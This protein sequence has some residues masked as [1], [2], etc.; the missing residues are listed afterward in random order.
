MNMICVDSELVYGDL[1]AECC[2]GE[3]RVGRVENNLIGEKYGLHA[4]DI[5]Y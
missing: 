4:R 3:V 5:W 2:K 1:V